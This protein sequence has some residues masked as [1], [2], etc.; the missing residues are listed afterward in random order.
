MSTI[1]DPVAAP[2]TYETYLTEGV[3]E[4]ISPSDSAGVLAGKLAD[5]QKVGVRECWIVEPDRRSVELLEISEDGFHSLGVYSDGNM[6]A[7]RA[8]PGLEVAVDEIFT[9]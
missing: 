3:V 2:L 6:L 4:I 5:Y 1:Q 9:D 8:F 7:S